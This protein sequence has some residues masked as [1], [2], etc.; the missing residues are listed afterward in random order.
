ML[1]RLFV[2]TLGLL[3]GSL[4]CTQSANAQGLWIGG[5]GFGGPGGYPGFSTSFYPGIYSGVY[6]G[7]YGPGFSPYGIGNRSFYSGFNTGF[8]SG[9]NAGRSVQVGVPIAYAGLYPRS[10]GLPEESVSSARV[11]QRDSFG[12]RAAL[13]SDS[14]TRERLRNCSPSGGLE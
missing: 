9:L 8:Y 2:L 4:A 6:S 12:H 1:R 7:V 10:D 14:R 3:C 13:P 5:T 11:W